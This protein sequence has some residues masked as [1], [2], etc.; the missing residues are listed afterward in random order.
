MEAEGFK[1]DRRSRTDAMGREGISRLLLR[2]SA[3]AIIAAEAAAGYNLFDAIWCG[4]LGAEALA[5]LSVSAPLMA[6]YRAVGVGIATGTASLIARHLGSGRREEA[7]KAAG[8]SISLFFMVSAVTVIICLINLEILL[9]AFGADDS[10]LPHA[11]SYMFIETC[12]MPIDFFL[13]VLAELV[14][15][16]GK[17][18][19]SSFCMFIASVVDI[20][21]S[22][23][24]VF[25][26]GPFPSLGIAGAALGTTIGRSVG[27]SILLVY[28]CLG[29]SIYHFKPDYFIP[30]LKIIVDIYRIGISATLRASV[31]SV[32]QILACRAAASFGIVPL[33]VLGILYKIN[34]VV[35]SFYIGLSQ[36]MLP[37]VGYNFGA[38]KNKRV[39]EI[40]VKAGIVSCIWGVLWFALA[41]SFPAQ[42]L[43]LFSS[44][45]DFINAGIQALQIFA[46][47]FIFQSVEF[48]ASSFFQGIGKAFYSLLATSSRSLIFSIP[49]LLV[50]P[51][52]FGLTGLWAV[53][54]LAAV[55][56]AVLNLALTAITFRSL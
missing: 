53:F 51:N 22:P 36:G 19:F 39:G 13:V 49:S 30:K 48:F 25:G 16:E 3:P 56:S 27:V 37:L 32:T 23:V 29:R 45:V 5:A 10:V 31:F 40:V 12:S 18:T 55:L 6:I 54:P 46:L 38:K 47:N 33:A 50:M 42:V 7:D 11:W 34:L 2:F 1:I 9:R 8:N 14:R 20:V 52:I 44:D 26:V 28:L 24:L 4:R 17:P 35:L 21:F 43:S 15:T 41:I